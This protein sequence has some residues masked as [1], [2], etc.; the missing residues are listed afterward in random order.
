MVNPKYEC[1]LKCPWPQHED[2]TPEV[3]LEIE[4][5]AQRLISRMKA[6][7]AKE[8]AKVSPK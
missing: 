7:S 4:E 3:A 6:K 5:F 8:E 2:L 1:N